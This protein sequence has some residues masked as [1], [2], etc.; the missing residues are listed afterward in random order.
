[1]MH[2]TKKNVFTIALINARSI[3]AKLDSFYETLKELGADVCLLTET[4]L[5]NTDKINQDLEDF[6]HKCGYAFLRKDRPGEK[7][8]GGVA[9]CYRSDTVNFVKAKIPPS[10]HEVYAAVGRRVGQRRK[11]VVLVVYLPP[12]YNAEQNRSLLRYINDAVQALKSKYDDPY[13]FVGGDFN[14]RIFRQAVIDH[15]ELKEVD[16]GSTRGNVTLDIIASNIN[17]LVVDS[18]TVEPIHSNEGTPSDHLTVFASFRMPRVPSYKIESYSY[19]HLTQDS[20]QLFG[21]WLGGVDWSPVLAE[22]DVDRSVEKLH[23][24]YEEGLQTAYTLKSRTKK[25]S[26]PPWMSDWLRKDIATRRRVFRNDTKRSDRWKVLKRQTAAAVKRRRKRHNEYMLAKFDT[27][28]NPGNFFHHVKGLVGKNESSRW[29][30][31][32]MYPGRDTEEVADILAAYFNN[33]SS[34]YSPLDAADVP[35]TFS[36]PPPQ[37]STAEVEEKMKKAKKPTSTVPGDIPAV[38]FGMFPTKLSPPV[39]HIFNL[40]TNTKCWPR[41]WKTEYVTVI[42]KTKDPQEPSECRNIACTNFLSKLY[43][44]ILLDWSRCEV[45]PKNNQYGGEPRASATHLLVE[46]MSDITT[47]LEDNRAGV[48]ISAIDFSKAFNRLDHLECLR[49]FAKKGSPTEILQLLAAFLTG[50]SMTVRLEGVQSP[51]R[52]VNAGA[53]QGSVLGCYL[54]NVGVDDLEE[55]FEDTSETQVDAHPETLVRTDDFPAI[56]T[57]TRVTH[58]T[59]LSDSPIAPR[60]DLSF[61]ILPRVANVPHWFKKPKDP[62]FRPSQL[63]TYKYVDDEVN[64]NKVNMRKSKLL[65]EHDVF[66][67]E[68]VDIR[69]QRLLEHI[70]ASAEAKG[71]AINASKTGLMLV[72]A[73]CSFNARVRLEIGG[74][75][76]L[77]QE[78]LKILGVTID[79]NGS[80]KTHV[81]KLASRH[82]ARTW[83]LT[84]LKKKGLD[85][86]KLVRVYK[87]LIRPVAEYASPA[88]H[89]ALTAAQAAH[90]ERQQVQAL[91]NIFGPDLSAA[92]LR[93]KAGVDLLSVRREAAVRKFGLKNLSNPRCHSWF[94]KRSATAYPRRSSITY[95]TYREDLARTDRHRNTPKNYIVRKVNEAKRQ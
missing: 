8:G 29:S 10:K 66:F 72:S 65:V 80:F 22:K 47:G 70:T 85:S 64:T 68:I 92:K 12:Y 75:T 36:K 38:L 19:R 20:H 79:S 83:A 7:R 44:S 42:P 23:A 61:S 37:L 56:S 58:H 27:E 48:V 5:K 81:N 87:G 2:Q 59:E 63:S 51:K 32:Q 54:F 43:E 55:G 39:T 89:S 6:K 73:A 52:T 14:R 33:I 71:M 1:M 95:P 91:K 25:S 11:V 62:E 90:L 30:P 82:R 76:I 69:T 78:S 74:Q 4:W 16:T 53:P 77:G 46:V 60:T 45:R 13:I 3:K 41:L 26:E 94:T 9:V 86:D 50:R 93:S 31:T 34:Q 21:Q 84:K 35:T 57:P 88:W 28:Q 40:I 49:S 18:G 17:E 15:P 24:I 67:K